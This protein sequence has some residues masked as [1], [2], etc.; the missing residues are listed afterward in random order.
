MLLGESYAVKEVT[1]GAEYEFRVSA[2]N[3]SG[4]GDL[5]PPSAMV[6]AKNP[7]SEYF[8]LFIRACQ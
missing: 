1:E 5:S 3:E 2:I 7:N 4:A 8:T 6:C